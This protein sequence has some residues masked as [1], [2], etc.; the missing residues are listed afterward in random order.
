[1]R[2]ILLYLFIYFKNVYFYFKCVS[3][4]PTCA[5]VYNVHAWLSEEGKKKFSESLE[6][7]LQLVVSCHMDSGN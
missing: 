6:L 1:M 7:E 2:S 5:Y 3:V 4:L